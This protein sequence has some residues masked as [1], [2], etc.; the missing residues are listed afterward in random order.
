[1]KVNQHIR[2]AVRQFSFSFAKG[3]LGYPLLKGID[4][5]GGRKQLRRKLE[6]CEVTAWKYTI[7]LLSN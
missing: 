2:G 4:Y 7:L 6:G 5:I 3:T 1:M